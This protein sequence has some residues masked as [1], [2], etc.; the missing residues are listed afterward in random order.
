MVIEFGLVR[1]HVSTLLHHQSILLVEKDYHFLK[2]CIK[3]GKQWFS[4]I[5]CVQLEKT[6]S[7]K[8]LVTIITNQ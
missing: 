7:K 6:L 8:S 5:V 3:V 1:I 4:D 2:M